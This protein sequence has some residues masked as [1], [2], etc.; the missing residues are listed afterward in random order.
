[1]MREAPASDSGTGR[2][3]LQRRGSAQVG[4]GRS[5]RLSV[6]S[7][8]GFLLGFWFGTSLAALTGP[9]L[10]GGEIRIFEALVR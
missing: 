1:M 2:I 7:T 4:G 10:F 6:Y 8:Q 5:V 3:G 9:T